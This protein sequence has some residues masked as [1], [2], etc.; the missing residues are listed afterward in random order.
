MGFFNNNIKYLRRKKGF[1]SREKWADFLE[2]STGKIQEY[3]RASFPKEEF[4]LKLKSKTQIDLDLFLTVEI[5]EDNYPQLFYKDKKDPL[6]HDHPLIH[7]LMP[8]LLAIKKQLHSDE[9]IDH[10]ITIFW[11]MVNE[12]SVLNS[13]LADC[14]RVRHDL[15]IKSK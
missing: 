13:K 5:N 4:I 10:V 11:E 2:E 1:S 8:K 3:E 14:F 7:D 6:I 9:E 12:I 15:L